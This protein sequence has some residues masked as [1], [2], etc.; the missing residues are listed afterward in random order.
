LLDRIKQLNLKVYN[1]Y[2]SFQ[3]I[4]YSNYF[5]SG[6]TYFFKAIRY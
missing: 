3:K 6:L 1:S 4:G 5:F 2:F